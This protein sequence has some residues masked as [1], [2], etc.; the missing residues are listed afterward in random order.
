MW[1]DV[2]VPSGSPRLRYDI[3]MQQLGVAVNGRKY[4]NIPEEEQITSRILH[5]NRLSVIKMLGLDPFLAPDPIR[6]SQYGMKFSAAPPVPV[7]HRLLRTSRTGDP[8]LY[9]TQ[10]AL[11]HVADAPVAHVALTFCE[12]TRYLICSWICSG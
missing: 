5:L 12:G 8:Q 11:W 7:A 3:G 2:A 1:I 9:L 4:S 6:S 10:P